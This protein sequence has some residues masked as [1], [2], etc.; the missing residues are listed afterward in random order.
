MPTYDAI[1]H[2]IKKVGNKTHVLLEVDGDFKP[3]SKTGHC[4]IEVDPKRKTYKT[5]RFF[6]ALMVDISRHTGDTP[7]ELKEQMKE[8]AEVGFD[9]SD[10]KYS[11]T[12]ATRK[13]A[14]KTIE[15]VLG[16][17]KKADIPLSHKS[18]QY[19]E[20]E[21]RVDLCMYKKMCLICGAPAN[22]HHVDTIGMGRDRKTVDDS[23]SRM[24]PLC[25][26]HHSEIHNV[27]PTKFIEKYCLEEFEDFLIPSSKSV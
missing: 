4:F 20:A 7:I 21:R 16:L 2:K 25:F 26:R 12:R 15:H 8:D 10:G 17:V 11:W 9:K 14:N 5:N 19:M 18:I 3:E 22:I 13:E 1:V 27:G 23:E 24:A 6:H